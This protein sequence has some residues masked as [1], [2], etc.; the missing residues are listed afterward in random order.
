VIFGTNPLLPTPPDARVPTYWGSGEGVIR[1]HL[2]TNLESGG[3][4]RSSFSSNVFL[5]D[6][7]V[8][9]GGDTVIRQG[10]LT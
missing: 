1:L 6:P 5:R 10:R 4:F 2:G 3:D 8:E 9:A 7:T